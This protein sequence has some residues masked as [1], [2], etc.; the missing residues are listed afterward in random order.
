MKI[1][2]DALLASP[3]A[4]FGV[5]E[6]QAA[7][8]FSRS[9]TYD[10][11]KTE[12]FPAV[13]SHGPW[14]RAEVIEW[15][16]TQ[17]GRDEELQMWKELMAS[18]SSA[19]DNQSTRMRGSRTVRYGI[20]PVGEDRVAYSCHA[21]RGAKPQVLVFHD[22]WFG[23]NLEKAL[24]VLAGCQGFFAAGNDSVPEV[25]VLVVT[26]ARPGVRYEDVGDEG[27]AVMTLATRDD[28]LSGGRVRDPLASYVPLTVIRDLIGYRLPRVAS[29]D[30]PLPADWA[31]D[32]PYGFPGGWTGEM[33]LFLRQAQWWWGEEPHARTL[34][35]DEKKLQE[36]SLL[37]EHA[38]NAL[39][40]AISQ[41]LGESVWATIDRD[42]V[43]REGFPEFEVGLGGVGSPGDIAAVCAVAAE[44]REWSEL[45]RPWLAEQTAENRWSQMPMA[46]AWLHGYCRALLE[47]ERV[48]INMD[49]L[50]Q[51]IV[52]ALRHR[53]RTGRTFTSQFPDA[54]AAWVQ[55]GPASRVQVRLEP[56]VL[57]E[58]DQVLE[59]VEP[60]SA[61][62]LARGSDK[63][64]LPVLVVQYLG[65]P[66]VRRTEP[67]GAEVE[68]PARRASGAAVRARVAMYV[69]GLVRIT[70]VSN[71][72]GSAVH[73]NRR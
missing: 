71:S 72:V 4:I 14:R 52:T 58:H 53:A 28:V 47:H 65:R 45:P 35:G 34:G 3:P 56:S 22:P 17:L 63:R 55:D 19:G 24:G 42:S 16:F 51:A 12:S 44:L 8:G 41:D 25:F 39:D 70:E 15:A 13:T 7:L 66:G 2:L 18:A 33:V 43:P 9:H 6:L 57:T 60:P 40:E 30:V 36:I 38:R 67:V 26:S 62:V 37:I 20:V 29:S 23:L 11:S 48:A 5:S 73:T 69:D 59:Q 21:P 50:P 68:V 54:N 49:D 1:D 31:P 32:R 46:M 10:L 64:G 27:A 61:I